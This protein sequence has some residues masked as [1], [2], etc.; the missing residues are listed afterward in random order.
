MTGAPDIADA[1]Q[2]PPRASHGRGGSIRAASRDREHGLPHPGP[3]PPSNENGPFSTDNVEH[4]DDHRT[5]SSVEDGLHALPPPA[6]ARAAPGHSLALLLIFVT[7][8][9][10]PAPVGLRRRPGRAGRARADGGGEKRV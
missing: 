7:A 3:P 6:R 10:P 4:D 2:A 8:V 5:L 9:H 1:A